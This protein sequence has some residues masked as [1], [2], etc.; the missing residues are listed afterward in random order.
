MDS[1]IQILVLTAFLA[2]GALCVKFRIAP[3][4]KVTDILIK[5]ALWALL[6]V[7]GFR[8]GNDPEVASRIGQIGILGAAAAAAALAGTLAAILA[9]YAILGMF[10]RGAPEHPRHGETARLGTGTGASGSS[11][12]Q[13]RTSLLLLSVVAAGGLF[14]ILLPPLT[15]IDL[16][17]IT[18]WV[19]NALLFFVG[20]QFA[21][22][23]LSFKA[24]FLRPDTLMIPVA[25]AVG[26]ILGGLAL[27]PLFRLPAGHAMSLTAG[28][29]WYSLSGVLIANL[30]N[31]VLGSAAFLANLFRESLAF[32]TIPLLARTRW[33]HLAIGAGG[34]TAMDVTLPLIEQCVGPES[35]PASFASGALLSLSVPVLVPFLFGLGS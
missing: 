27:A 14:G 15:G 20:M 8:T 9:G 7:M 17:T 30:G 11:A 35:V 23:G 1:I 5:I 31:P 21:Q 34:A 2:G 18:G 3:P 24:V 10:R 29:G 25:T 12:S 13:L 6:F 26:S 33:P 19:L 16:G 32:L 4:A 22:S 28:F